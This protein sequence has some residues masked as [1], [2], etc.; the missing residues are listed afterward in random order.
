MSSKTMLRPLAACAVLAA[1]LAPQVRGFVAPFAPP[2]SRCRFLLQASI[3]EPVDV[4]ARVEAPDT[5]MFEFRPPSALDAC[6]FGLEAPA[7]AGMIG[8]AAVPTRGGASA[9]ERSASAVAL[10]QP[11]EEAAGSSIATRTFH[12]R[13]A[14]GDGAP[15]GAEDVVVREGIC[16]FLNDGGRIS[17]LRAEPDANNARLSAAFFAKHG[18]VPPIGAGASVTTDGGSGGDGGALPLLRGDLGAALSVVSAA[19]AVSSPTP[20]RDATLLN[21]QARLLH[22][23][24]QFDAA[25]GSYLAAVAAE[26]TRA[27]AFRGLGGAYQSLGQHQMAFA[28]YQQAINLAP[29][30]AAAYLKLGMLYEQLAVGKYEGAADHAIQCYRH[31]LAAEEAAAAAAAAEKAAATIAARGYGE[32]GGNTA[33]AGEETAS[34]TEVAVDTDVLVRLGNL[35]VR[36]L[37]PEAAVVTYR[38]ALALDPTLSNAWFN[39]ATAHL[40]LRDR[41]AAAEALRR[42]LALEPG[43]VAAR[44]MLASLGGDGAAIGRADRN[45]HVGALYDVTAEGYDDHM[46]KKLLYTAPRILRQAVR[47]HFNGTIFAALPADVRAAHGG[48]VLRWLNGSLDILDLGCGTGLCGSWF[49]DY[50]R[51][52]VGVDLSQTMVDMATKKGCYD[53]LK[54]QDLEEFLPG[55]TAGSYDVV[56]AADSLHYLGA[57]EDVFAEAARVLRPG[58]CLAV[59]IRRLSAAGEDGFDSVYDADGDAARRSGGGSG[60]GGVDVGSGYALQEEGTYAYARA[61]VEAAATKAGLRVDVLR[62][63]ASRLER[64]EPLPGYLLL[65]VKSA[66]E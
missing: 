64:G 65:A 66:A 25:V 17:Q 34:A 28:S 62:D 11:I 19:L 7:L 37:A 21:I 22:D 51:R 54:R 48:D 53:V 55:E 31:Y 49:T 24:G 52:S 45:R 42:A 36:R 9:A 32:G 29:A 47:E 39:L 60:G 63:Y 30:D 27:S 61:Y 44:Y 43:M 1:Y 20:P 4:P 59:T 15:A 40:K 57:L 41:A 38:R 16:R 6:L 3:S 50:A 35:E 18:L 33:A 13:M 23:A 12:L 58:G 8:A 14:L 10:I 2:S 26:P 46:R 56:V 5:V